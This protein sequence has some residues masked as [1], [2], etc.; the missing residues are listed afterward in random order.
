MGTGVPLIRGGGVQASR[1][2]FGYIDTAT[3][4]SNFS[5]AILAGTQQVIG[6]QFKNLLTGGQVAV[7]VGAGL[8][9]FASAASPFSAY[10]NQTINIGSIG[11]GLEFYGNLIELM[12]VRDLHTVT[13]Y[14]A[15]P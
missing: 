9:A 10:G 7:D 12:F 3:N 13:E 6:W 1:S 15:V 2:W 14:L 8:G 11:A 4:D 5:S